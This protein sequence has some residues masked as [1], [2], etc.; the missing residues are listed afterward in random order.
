[1]RNL[2]LAGEWRRNIQFDSSDNVLS[3]DCGHIVAMF[4][5][6]GDGAPTVDKSKFVLTSDGVLFKIAEDRKLEWATHLDKVCSEGCR[7]RW[8]S[9]AYLETTTDEHIACIS[10]N[11]A[12]VTVSPVTG[13]AELCGE[14]EYGLEGVCWS[15]DRESLLLLTF[16]DAGNVELSDVN[17]SPK[18]NSVLLL[19]NSR[20][21]VLAETTIDNHVPTE[22][23]VE[24]SVLLSY[25]PDGFL[26]AVSTVDVV[27]NM[28]KIRFFNACSLKL[29]AIGRTEDGS[30]KLVPG[31]IA[32]GAIAW[33]G[34]GCSHLL[35]AA[36]RKGK[37]TIQIIFFE[38]NGL[39]HR[40]FLLRENPNTQ[41][42]DLTW[43]I[44]SDLLAVSLRVEGGSDKVQLWHRSNYHWYMKQELSYKTERVVRAVFDEERP[45]VL[46]V[47][48]TRNLEWR[49]YEFL[50]QPS[51]V[52]LMSGK[53]CTAYAID[54][55]LL[56]MTPLDKV[57]I[58]PPMYGTTSDM[59]C[60]IRHV[61]FCRNDDNP[62]GSVV[63]LSD[64]TIVLLGKNNGHLRPPEVL[65]KGDLNHLHGMD[66]T[67]LRSL[68]IVDSKASWLRLLGVSCPSS[69]A[70]DEKLITLTIIRDKDNQM[71]SISRSCDDISLRQPVLCASLWT[72]ADKGALVALRDG[73][74]W[75]FSV[76]NDGLGSLCPCEGQA[77]I[78]PCPWVAG[79]RDV[80]TLN[81]VDE[82]D[83]SDVYGD[84]VQKRLIFGLSS[85]SRLYC[86]DVLLADNV[87]S[88]FV[89]KEHQFLCYCTAQGSASQ[90]RF[91][92]LKDLESF[93]IL[94]GSDENH[95]LGGFDP[96]TVERGARVVAILPEAPQ[97]ILQLPR[98]NLEGIYPRALVLRYVMDK[99]RSAKYGDAFVMMRRQ[100]VN[101]NLI[102]DLKPGKF[103]T[104]DVS[105]FLEQVKVID[106][107][108][109]FISCLQNWD[110]TNAQ[111]RIPPWFHLDA[112][113]D[114]EAKKL[115]DFST[116]VN[117]V[118]TKMR[119][120]MLQAE[121]DGFLQHGQAVAKGHF[122]LPILSTFA[123]ESPPK[124]EEALQLIKTNAGRS[125]SRSKKPPLFS[126]TAQSSI[127]YLAFLAD[128]EVSSFEISNGG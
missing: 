51:I 38:S 119:S 100:K 92:P 111:Y 103:L 126:D 12:I 17:A 10:K 45:N 83:L 41:I 33:A 52:Q 125:S 74:L 78:E 42:L 84:Q 39:R 76:S 85:R 128:Y 36:Q 94:M 61:A 62:V 120:V 107:L 31:I 108:N 6:V 44:E 37:K 3:D 89:S 47:Y 72:D 53:T 54:G 77:F 122:L 71:A 69:K 101:L 121:N 105:I 32:S 14:F 63:F 24:S 20:W 99:I 7:G 48:F 80:S 11:G 66:P 46:Y 116:K 28:R 29:H 55:S 68:L 64:G 113:C 95:V 26:C 34:P 70:S 35:A 9:M 79:L 1:M 93:D 117:Q 30:G 115:F 19:M 123:K 88:F 2:S 27:D 98:G 81:Y 18:R 5:T 109:L 58:P 82:K 21:E 86:R 15:P 56:H 91:L 50:W 90:L 114:I 118:C 112:E 43:N 25:R 49:E 73:S 110:S 104:S 57:L 8:F 60:P 13:Y 59:G 102:V 97:A 4:Q 23:S 40:E 16:E 75:E 96:R 124:L 127:Q 65:A 22:Q 87:S 67:S 106:H